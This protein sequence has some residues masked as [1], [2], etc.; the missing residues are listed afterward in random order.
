[1]SD[2]DQDDE[3]NGGLCSACKHRSLRIAHSLAPRPSPRGPTRSGW[4]MG[5]SALGC[6]CLSASWVSAG[7]A[8]PPPRPVSWTPCSPLSG[9]LLYADEAT[10]ALL[11]TPPDPPPRLA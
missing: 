5:V 11:P 3:D 10:E 7:A 8:I 9:K 6:R 4:V 2:H 1:V